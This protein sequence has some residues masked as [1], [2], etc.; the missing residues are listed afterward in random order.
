MM[1][2][3][4]LAPYAVFTI[5]MLVSSAAISL[6][7]SAA[8]CLA[9]ICVDIYYGRSIKILG[10]GSVVTFV[11]IGAYV[12]LIDPAFSDS[13]VKFSVDTGVFLISLGSLL[14]RYPFTLQYALEVV[15]PETAKL[16]G[17]VRANYIITAAWTAASLLMMAG[18][19]AMIYVPGLPFWVGL[20]VVFA[21]RNIT[22]YFTHWYPQYQRTKHGTPPS[23]ALRGTN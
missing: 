4:I 2:F 9:V 17:F 13:A 1:I 3:L 23:S 10:A 11:A 6:F 14:M 18:N 20:L 19:A 5:L 7:V 15:D 21:V 22:V 12:S 16:A 8:V